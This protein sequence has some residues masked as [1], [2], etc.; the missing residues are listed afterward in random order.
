[1]IDKLEYAERPWGFYQVL[2]EEP[3]YKVKKICVNPQGR[4][5]LQRHKHRTE[6]WYIVEG[7]ARIHL[8]KELFE[9]EAG[10]SIDIPREGIHR[11]ENCGTTRL[12]FIEVQQGEYLGEDDIERLS[13]DYGRSKG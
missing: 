2:L 10:R 8:D 1:M 4:L 6:H 12:I 11:I 3:H 5:S 9:L 13:D 7:K